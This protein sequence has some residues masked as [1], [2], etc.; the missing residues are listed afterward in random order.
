[1]SSSPARLA[2]GFLALAAIWIGVYWL[3]EPSR[4]AGVSFSDP[5]PAERAAEGMVR[6]TVRPELEPQPRPVVAPEPT[7]VEPA[8]TPVPGED[9]NAAAGTQAGRDG[10]A[11]GGG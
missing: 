11:A 8:P 6:E 3:W 7:P 2:G 1:M 5:Q 4:S 10:D 9:G